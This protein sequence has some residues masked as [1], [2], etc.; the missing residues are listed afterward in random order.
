MRAKGASIV[1][2]GMRKK[3]GHGLYLSVQIYLVSKGD[4]TNEP[5]GASWIALLERT[6]T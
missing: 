3:R 4:M 1:I 5:V 6:S 2:P